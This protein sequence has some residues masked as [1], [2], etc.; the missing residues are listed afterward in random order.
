M[1][2]LIS[3]HAADLSEAVVPGRAWKVL[4]LDR[5][6]TFESLLLGATYAMAF[7]LAA[8]VARVPRHARWVLFLLV[9]LGTFEAFYG[10]VEQLGGEAKVFGYS[11]P[12][13][14]RTSGTYVNPN[15]YAAFL[16]MA[17]CAALGLATS[18]STS[19]RPVPRDLKLRVIAALTHPAAP[20]RALFAF[21]GVAMGVALAGSLSRGGVLA[22]LLG[23]GALGIT[24]TRHR[25]GAGGRAGWVLGAVLVAGGWVAAIGVQTLLERFGHLKDGD[26]S[27]ASRLAFAYDTIMIA[28]AH[29][30]TGVGAGAF[31][32]VY[33][34]FASVELGGLTLTHAHSDYAELLAE[35]G[36]VGVLLLLGS[37]A[38]TA[39]RAWPPADEH[40][41]PER[42][43]IA[44]TALAAL[45]PLAA[46]S[47]VD[48]NLRIP[49]NA[50]WAATLLGV[51][52]G[53]SQPL[54]VRRMRL[55]GG[56]WLRLAALAGLGTSALVLALGAVQL[57]RGDW[58]AEPFV[59]RAQGDPRPL[60][61]RVRS[62]EA[63]LGM[64]PFRA[65]H[66]AVLGAYRFEVALARQRSAAREAA[67]AL[68][69][70]QRTLESDLEA[71]IEALLQARLMHDPSWPAEVAECLVLL[72]RA[73]ALA[74][75]NQRWARAR[76]DLLEVLPTGPR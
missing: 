29:P 62:H 36:F 5:P 57:A 50:L 2:E 41:Q 8:A 73:C 3:P 42:G 1:V 16:G 15:H 37:V 17:I 43:A 45:V 67:L 51:A 11:K 75:A 12:S 52:W 59:E 30:L 32:A 34:R 27:A 6:A 53:V 4:S 64:W 44:L 31:E 49:A 28:F 19:D 35:L 69:D 13:G 56:W 33:P 71:V 54:R 39:W 68:V 26:L 10:L 65:D 21:L 47:L 76:A 61:Q 7:G 60:L 20:R 9:G 25:G 18:T 70:P 22:C 38:L 66:F 24:S 55:P 46:H 14:G 48:F 40:A 63:A 72:E 23:L 74:P 58:V